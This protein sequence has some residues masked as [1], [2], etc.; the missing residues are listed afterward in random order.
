ML[1]STGLKQHPHVSTIVCPNWPA[2]PAKFFMVKI[3]TPT[4]K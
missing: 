3:L 4:H 1:D 2:L